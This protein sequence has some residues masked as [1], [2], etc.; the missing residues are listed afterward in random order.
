MNAACLHGTKRSDEREQGR[1]AGARGTGHDDDFARAE[2]EIVFVQHLFAILAAPEK[3]TQRADTH[4][5]FHSLNRRHQKSSAGSIARALRT[6]RRPEI[7]HIPMVRRRTR[8][9]GPNVSW[10]TMP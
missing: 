1:F 4:D 6:A 5:W 7:R 2:I 9:T 3:M 10:V 8:P